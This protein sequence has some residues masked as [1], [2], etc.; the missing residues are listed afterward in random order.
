MFNNPKLI[1]SYLIKKRMKVEAGSKP[2]YKE[3]EIISLRRKDRKYKLLVAD[4][5]RVYRTER[6]FKPI[7]AFEDKLVKN[8]SDEGDNEDITA[9]NS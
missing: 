8:C 5:R 2:I 9:S 7:P 6:T 4:I 1:L 3:R